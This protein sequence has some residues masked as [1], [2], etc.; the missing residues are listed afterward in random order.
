M[1][2]RT[3][4]GQEPQDHEASSVCRPCL[5]AELAKLA[6]FFY[7]SFLL[8]GSL[9]WGLWPWVACIRM[10]AMR[11]SALGSC[12]VHEL[13]CHCLFELNRALRMC[14]FVAL[15]CHRISDR[16]RKSRRNCT[17]F[18]FVLGW[19][20]VV[21]VFRLDGTSSPTR[22]ARPATSRIYYMPGYIVRF[23]QG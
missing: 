14:R 23:G 18:S 7:Y 9:G 20:G 19:L 10:G 2:S 16:T 1:A 21:E 6:F 11:L 15:L 3:T 12:M 22:S 5:Q 8:G 17:I 13:G 4:E